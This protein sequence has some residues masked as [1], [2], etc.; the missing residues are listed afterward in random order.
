[1]YFYILFT[2]MHTQ[3]KKDSNIILISFNTNM[4]YDSKLSIINYYV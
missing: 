1:M 2:L 4:E 3:I